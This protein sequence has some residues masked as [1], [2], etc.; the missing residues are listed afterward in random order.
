MVVQALLL[1]LSLSPANSPAHSNSDE[2]GDK[3]A[4]GAKMERDREI[5]HWIMPLGDE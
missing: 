5:R 2:F 3:S 1:A 4:A